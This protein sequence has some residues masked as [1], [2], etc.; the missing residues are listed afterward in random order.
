MFDY[1]RSG[2]Y[3]GDFHPFIKRFFDHKDI[4]ANHEVKYIKNNCGNYPKDHQKL[5]EFR[6]LADKI[7]FRERKEKERELEK[8]KKDWW[9]ESGMFEEKNTVGMFESEKEL[10]QINRFFGGNE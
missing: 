10:E 1:I 2:K 9:R 5:D 6:E 4:F 8:R 7:K 3:D